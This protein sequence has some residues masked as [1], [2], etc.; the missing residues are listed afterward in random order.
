MTTKRTY[1]DTLKTC[2]AAAPSWLSSG[3]GMQRRFAVGGRAMALVLDLHNGTV[4]PK[5]IPGGVSG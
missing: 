4:R 1:A 3:S 5:G 2:G